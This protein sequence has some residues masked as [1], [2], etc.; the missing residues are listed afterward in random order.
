M[1]WSQARARDA[2]DVGVVVSAGAS[3]V[4]EIGGPGVGAAGVVGEV[5]DRVAEL[6]VAGPAET[7]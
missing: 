4:V 3:A 2:G 7:D 1:M 6:F 5:A